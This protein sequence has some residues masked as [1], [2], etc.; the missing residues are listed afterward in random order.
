MKYFLRWRG[1]ENG[2]LVEG[3]LE[4]K[5]KLA[6]PFLKHLIVL[7]VGEV[8]IKKIKRGEQK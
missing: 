2:K 8:I 5:P 6:E 3:E 1:K 4:V 7:K